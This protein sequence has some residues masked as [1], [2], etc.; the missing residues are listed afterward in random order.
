MSPIAYTLVRIWAWEETI[1]DY[2]IDFHLLIK[3]P[4]V[5]CDAVTMVLPSAVPPVGAAAPQK[6]R[7]SNTFLSDV[8]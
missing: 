2:C 1:E 7:C 5:F 8:I 4:T 3:P 6:R